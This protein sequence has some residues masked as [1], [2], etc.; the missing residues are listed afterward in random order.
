[1]K[2]CPS[3]TGQPLPTAVATR[4]WSG[5]RQLRP[6]PLAIGLTSTR[7]AMAGTFQRGSL[8]LSHVSRYSTIRRRSVL[9]TYFIALAEGRRQGES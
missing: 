4:G 5:E 7:K 3:S 2:P 1:M 8:L 9:E 6:A